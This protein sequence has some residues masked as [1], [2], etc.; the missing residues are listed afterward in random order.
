MDR[1]R[2]E[3]GAT[4]VAH[5]AP[6]PQRLANALRQQAQG[7]P[8]ALQFA[9]VALLP[10][11]VLAG[12]GTAA[13]QLAGVEPGA[14]A[15]LAMT[16]PLVSITALPWAAVAGAAVAALGVLG[17]GRRVSA[18]LARL[19]EAARQMRLDE[20]PDEL[21]LPLLDTNPELLATSVALRR[22]VEAHRAQRQALQVRIGQLG[23]QLQQRTHEL[24]TLQDLSIGLAQSTDLLALVDEALAALERTVDFSSASVWARDRRSASH[25]VMLM[26]YRSAETDDS[27]AQALRGRRLSRANLQVY[28]QIER[29]RCPH[30]DNQAR[31]GLLTWLWEKVTD[32]AS[33]STLYRNTRAWMGLPLQVRDT[34]LGVL[35]VDHREPGYFDPARARLLTAVSSQTALAMHHAQ[36][37]LQERELAVVAERN[38]I[39]RELH[40]AVSQ[41]LFAANVIAGTLARQAE[42]GAGTD[43]AALARQARSLEQ[44][45]RGALAEMRMLLFELRPDALEGQALPELLKHPIEALACRG[46]IVV[47][48]DIATS[49]PLA[50]GQ[51]AQVYRIAQELLT[52]L[53]RHSAAR[54]AWVRWQPDAPEGPT[55]R[56]RDDGQ[57][58]DTSAARPG[59]FGLD[60][61]RTRAAEIGARVRLTSAPGAGTEVCIVLDEFSQPEI[62]PAQAA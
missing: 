36:L 10:P 44:L 45:N 54:H 25:Q 61:V 49:D 29:E 33:T 24:S 30:I 35:R 42:R 43:V 52:N 58:F 1:R 26:G 56:I 60:N 17:F 11:L 12:L 37:M 59:H 27:G 6:W 21:Q 57:G 13:W 28:E 38:R 40:D 20:A 62:R 47:E 14:G 39:A 19:T 8:L 34:V 23:Q 5:A 48:A 53:A 46:D 18:S 22:L 15:N 7:W 50:P 3:P 2:P 9:L 4:G 51:R 16:P 31:Q 55:L 32:D 41:T